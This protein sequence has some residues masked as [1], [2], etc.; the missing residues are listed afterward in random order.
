MAALGWIILLALASGG[1]GPVGGLGV[2]ALWFVVSYLPAKKAERQL[3]ARTFEDWEMHDTLSHS[4]AVDFAEMI[5]T[6]KVDDIGWQR[7]RKYE[8]KRTD[9]GRWSKRYTDE[10]REEELKRLKEALAAKRIG[11]S[12]ADIDR[13]WANKWERLDGHFSSRIEV[14]YQAFLRTL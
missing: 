7:T 6:E 11:V 12:Q 1:A 14:A 13:A 8:M 2:L 10:T 5:A 3:E 4:F 9:A